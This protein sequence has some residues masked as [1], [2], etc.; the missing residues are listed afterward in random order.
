MI[1]ATDPTKAQL[2][3]AMESSRD[4]VHASHRPKEFAHVVALDTGR[5]RNMVTL[6]YGDGST[7][8][9]YPERVT[10]WKSFG[11]AGV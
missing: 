9:A 4:C 7:Y 6:R 8:D 1:Y 11:R 3:S 2:A 10:L 5:K